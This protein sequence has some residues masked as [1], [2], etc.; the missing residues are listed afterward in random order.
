MNKFSTVAAFTFLALGACRFESPSVEEQQYLAGQGAFAGGSPAWVSTA[1]QGKKAP[2]LI[3]ESF[4]APDAIRGR[5]SSD[6]LDEQRQKSLELAAKEKAAPQ[7]SVPDASPLNRINQVCPGVE[8]SVNDALTTVDL[9]ERIG[10]YA[11]L[12]SQC[13]SAYDLWIWLGNDYLKAERIPE[14]KRAFDQALVL[15]PGN[16]EASQGLDKVSSILNQGATKENLP[17]SE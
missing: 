3:P 1:V 6:L 16:T 12:T 4:A 7:K 8:S 9:N 13:S 2:N 17:A 15:N 11:S 10:K 5:L 14:A